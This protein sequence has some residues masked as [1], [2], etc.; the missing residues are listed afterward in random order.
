M[1]QDSINCLNSDCYDPI[2]MCNE[3]HRF[4]V[5]EQLRDNRTKSSKMILDLVGE[6]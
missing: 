5:T 6:M 4:I 1:I 2:I 3:E